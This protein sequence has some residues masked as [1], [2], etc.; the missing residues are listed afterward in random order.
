MV[1]L[2]GEVVSQSPLSGQ[3]LGNMTTENGK[4]IL[5]IGNHK[6][7]G[8]MVAEPKPL[9]VLRKITT[10]V[11]GESGV[12]GSRDGQARLQGD[13]KNEHR[14]VEYRIVGK[15]IRKTIFKTRPKPLIRKI[16]PKGGI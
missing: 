10:A 13:D 6:L 5:V 16:I 8:K 9:L 4:P 3:H 7:E 12:G 14:R 2:Q 11:E 1:E 15:V